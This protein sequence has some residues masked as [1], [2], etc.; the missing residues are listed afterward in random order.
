MDIFTT[1]RLRIRQLTPTD[2]DYWFRINGDPEVMQFIRPVQSRQDSDLFLLENILN[3]E[4]FPAYGR[5]I[6]E[7]RLN[8]AFI[9]MLMMRPLQGRPELELGYALEKGSWGKG[10]ATELVRGALE[11]AVHQL[12]QPGIIALTDPGNA[13]SQQVLLKCGFAYDQDMFVDGKLARM[14][15]LQ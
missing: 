12:K 9:G 1:P 7:D 5:W 10:Y 13:A 14:Y 2:G 11:Y 8:A 4:I 6:V 15:K 3:Y